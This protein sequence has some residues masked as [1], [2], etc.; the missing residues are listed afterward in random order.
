VL[1]FINEIKNQAMVN[2][3]EQAGFIYE[4]TSGLYWDSKTGYYYNPEC[5]LYYNGN[6]GNWYKLNPITNEFTFH[7]ATEAAKA[8]K[9]VHTLA[10]GVDRLTSHSILSPSRFTNRQI[11]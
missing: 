5:D 8:A 1:D 10:L 4:P 7:S 11:A 2:S 6:D 9:K 3:F